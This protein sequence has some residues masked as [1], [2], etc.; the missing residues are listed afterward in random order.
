MLHPTNTINRKAKFGFCSLMIKARKVATRATPTI[1]I[2]SMAKPSLSIETR[3]LILF[4]GKGHP[5]SMRLGT[6]YK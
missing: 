4:S 3:R 6:K 2:I 5:Q 1:L